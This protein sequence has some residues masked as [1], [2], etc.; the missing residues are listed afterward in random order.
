MSSTEKAALK[1]LAAGETEPKSHTFKDAA[2][3]WMAA[4]CPNKRLEERPKEFCE[5]QKGRVDHLLPFFGKFGC[6]EIRIHLL[7]AYKKWRQPKIEKGTGERT[8]DLELVTLSNVLNYQVVIGKLD[9][10]YVRGGRPKFRKDADIRHCRVNAP[11]DAETLHA[12]ARSL[13]SNK[14][15]QSVGWMVLFAAFTGCRRSEL[16]RL[17]VDS[18]SPDQPGFIDG[19]HLFLRRSK[20]GVNPWAV[21][22]PE[23]QSMLDAFLQWHKANFPKSPWFFPG[24]IEGQPLEKNAINRALSRTCKALKLKHVSPHGLRSFYVTKRRSDGLLDSQIAAEIGDQDVALISKTYGDRPA[25]WRGGKVVNWVPEKGK[26]AWDL[27]YNW[28]TNVLRRFR[29]SAQVVDKHGA[30]CRD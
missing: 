19:G 18:R 11:P 30:S 9:F 13:L 25:N 5:V 7:P 3:E 22:F 4:N 12:I 6:D 14:R 26:T 16:L 27:D 21:I 1:E 8:I 28:T 23:F 15:S 20:G 2:K 10:N 17:R 24:E 29:K